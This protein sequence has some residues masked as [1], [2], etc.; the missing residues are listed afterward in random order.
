V[1]IDEKFLHTARNARTQR[2]VQQQPQ[3]ASRW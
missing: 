3:A 2:V 1:I